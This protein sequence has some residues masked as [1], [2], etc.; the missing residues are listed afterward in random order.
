MPYRVHLTGTHVPVI[1]C[2]TG[3]RPRPKARLPDRAA[4]GKTRLDQPPAGGVISVG[5][6][7]D[8]MKMV[9]KHHPSIDLERPFHS[10]HP[11]CV[12]QSLDLKDQQIRPRLPQRNREKNRAMGRGGWAE[13][14]HA[15]TLAR[16]A[17]T[18]R[19]QD[20]NRTCDPAIHTQILPSDVARCVRCQKADRAR[21]FFN[22]AIATHGDA[23][24][25]L[26]LLG[27]AVDK[28]G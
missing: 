14:F 24:A 2:S 25:E 21:D 5:Q 12:T 27:Q 3:Q 11:H 23:G 15:H 19:Y 8:R 17:L 4:L 9:R 26:F 7:P 6:G 13:M 10:R 20:L 16:I 18:P 28:S 22:L 1:I